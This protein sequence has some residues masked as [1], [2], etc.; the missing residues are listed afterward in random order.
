MDYESDIKLI[1]KKVDSLIKTVIWYMSWINQDYIKDKIKKSYEYAKEAHKWQIRLS[2]HPYI[3][4]PVE[5]TMIL[6]S[7][8]PDIAS[9]QACLLHDVI[10]DTPKT[11]ADIEKEFWKEVAFLCSWMEKLWKVR[12]K[13]EDRAI[14]SLRKMFVAMAEDLR[15]ILIKLSDRLHNMQTLKYHPKLEKRR[16]IALETLNIYVPIAERLWLYNLKNSLEKEC[17]KILKKQDYLNIKKALTETK[18]VKDTFKKTS[19]EEIESLLKDIWVKWEVSFRIKSIYSIYRK[20]KKKHFEDINDLY[21]IYGIR[22]IVDS[23]ADCYRVL[24]EIHSRW[25]PLPYRFKDYIALAKPNW[26]RSLHTTVIG[27]LKNFVKQPTEIQIRTRE[28]HKEAEIWVA[29]HFEYK[30]V[31]SKVARDVNWVKELKEMTENLWNKDL[32]SSLKID[33][34]KDRIFVFSPKGDTVNLPS[35]STPID[36]AYYIHTDLWNHISVAKV[37]HSVYPLDK[38]LR[39]GD[40][41]DIVIDKNRSPSPFRLSFVKTSKAKS[42]IRSYLKK[43]NKDL[44]RDRGKDIL[45]KYL[46]SSWHKPLDKDL[47]IFK[48]IDW[49]EYNI[50]ERYQFLEQVWNFSLTPSSL[51]R[52]IFKPDSRSLKRIGRPEEVED[53]DENR[54]LKKKKVIIGWEDD[55]PYKICKK[56]LDQDFSEEIVAH[57]NSKWIFTLHRRDCDILEWANKDRLISAYIEWNEDNILLFEVSF[58]MRNKPWILKSISSILYS[59]NINID[60][61]YSKKQSPYEVKIVL[62]LEVPDHD[63]LILDRF[64]DRVKLKMWSDLLNHEISQ[65]DYK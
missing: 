55:L 35:W 48:V 11:Y 64:L 41:V 24:W 16:R 36:F 40:I 14:W 6:L 56:C 13:W 50:E 29:A 25:Y 3:N 18:I 53:F 37:N 1:D 42:R 49:R 8:S 58:I 61:I 20:M 60:E 12:Y 2:W 19:I 10:E 34:F 9:I 54:V 17:F 38:E 65:I 26:Y 62:S 27:F 45:N 47:S 28:M 21:D 46:E 22:I 33:V 63:Y 15:V 52:R 59:M 57:I 32:M 39:N 31:W 43:E 4:H 30:E 5:S 7:L 44:H 23:V 51:I